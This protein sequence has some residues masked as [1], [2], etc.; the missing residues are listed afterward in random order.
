MYNYR[1]GAGFFNPYFAPRSYGFVDPYYAAFNYFFPGHTFKICRTQ[2]SP[3]CH[4]GYNY[5]Y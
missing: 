4:G 3:K 1:Y 2:A 5:Y